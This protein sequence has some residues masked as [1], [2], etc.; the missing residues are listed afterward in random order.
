MYLTFS[1]PSTAARLFEVFLL[2]AFLFSLGGDVVANLV[3]P[4][5]EQLID[6]AAILASAPWTAMKLHLCK[7]DI[8]PTKATL[9]ADLVAQEADFVGYSAQTLTFSAGHVDDVGNVVALA[10]ANFLC[11]ANTTPNTLY[12]FYVTNTAGSVL[13]FSGRLDDA[14]LPIVNAGDGLALVVAAQ[15]GGGTCVPVG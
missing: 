2:C 5:A 4:N 12:T 15:L 10:M 13:M 9:L 1:R 6:L 8:S 3:Y 14:P 11:T 7:L